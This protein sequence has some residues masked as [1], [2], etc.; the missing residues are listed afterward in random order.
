[1]SELNVIEKA[2]KYL[3]A[4]NEETRKNNIEDRLDYYYDNYKDIIEDELKDQFTET[5]FDNIKLMIDDSINL[6][7]YIY[8]E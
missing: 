5:N 3:N 8:L 2:L 1:M 7:E 4:A 6:V